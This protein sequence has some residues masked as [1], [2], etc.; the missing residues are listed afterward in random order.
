MG[1]VGWR[2][3]G[4]W[5]VAVGAAAAALLAACTGPTEPPEPT[6]PPSTPPAP[7]TL[8]WSYGE[9]I[10]DPLAD[11]WREVAAEFEAAHPHVT[12]ELDGFDPYARYDARFDLANP[13]GLPDVFEH[14][15]APRLPSWCQP[16]SCATSP[17]TPRR[18]PG[19]SAR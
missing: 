5:V 6:P 13:D 7:V 10:S 1:P 16:G 15:R 3:R 2:R 4:A 18:S 19:A 9:P 8:T 12:V 14:P 17:T 11:L